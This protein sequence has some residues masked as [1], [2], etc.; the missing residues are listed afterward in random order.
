MKYPEI[1]KKRLMKKE[2]FTVKNGLRT[3]AR[4]ASCTGHEPPV[5]PYACPT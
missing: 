5:G 3:A 1:I 2:R 4:A